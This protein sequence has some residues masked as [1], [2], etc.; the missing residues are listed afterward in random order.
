ML[1]RVTCWRCQPSG[2]APRGPLPTTSHSYRP[3][4]APTHFPTQPR[5]GIADIPVCSGRSYRNRFSPKFSDPGFKVTLNPWSDTGVGTSLL[6]RSVWPR[7]QGTC[8]NNRL[9]PGKEGAALY[10]RVNFFIGTR[11]R[12]GGSR[13]GPYRAVT[14]PPKKER[15]LQHAY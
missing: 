15:W 9:T 3:P 13:R 5:S 12:K 14:R 10:H 4:P 8:D 11:F 6:S 1:K 7:P 2:G